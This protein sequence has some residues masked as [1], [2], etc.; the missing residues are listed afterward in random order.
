VIQAR[1][2]LTINVQIDR[3]HSAPWGMA[4]GE[5][6]FGN[7]PRIGLDGKNVAD[8]PNA[9]VLT[10]RL[11]PGDAY[12]LLAGG[13]GGFGLPTDR[14]RDHVVSDGARICAA[15]ERPLTSATNLY[16]GNQEERWQMLS[17][18][19]QFRQSPPAS[20]FETRHRASTA[21]APPFKTR[22]WPSPNTRGPRRGDGWAP[23]QAS[24]LPRRVGVDGFRRRD[25][26]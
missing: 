13:G 6:G 3:V 2:P 12:S 18:V 1:V 21:V 26:E 22:T 24:D 11:K 17:N 5:A 14:E 15:A 10:Q 16:F 23:C 8:L 25:G 9:K 7:E 20:V 4:G 19:E